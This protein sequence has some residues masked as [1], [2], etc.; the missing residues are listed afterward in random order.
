MITRVWRPQP[1]KV[2]KGPPTVGGI[3]RSKRFKKLLKELREE[4]QFKDIHID[5]KKYH[6]DPHYRYNIWGQY[7]PIWPPKPPKEPAFRPCR[8]DDFQVFK[9]NFVEEWDGD[10]VQDTGM[11]H[12]EFYDWFTT[13]KREGRED[14]DPRHWI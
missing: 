10:R 4:E 8:A 12:K 11:T 9:K 3:K 14:N 5:I 7:D 13:G 2:Y 1:L 6:S